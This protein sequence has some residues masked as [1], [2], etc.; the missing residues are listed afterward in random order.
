MLIAVIIGTSGV[1]GGH[2]TIE[3]IGQAMKQNRGQ[4]CPSPDKQPSENQPGQK[5]QGRYYLALYDDM[6]NC[7]ASSRHHYAYPVLQSAPA[8]N[9]A[10]ARSPA[11]CQPMDVSQ[12]ITPE[13]YFFRNR[14]VHKLI[15]YPAKPLLILRRQ[16]LQRRSQSAGVQQPQS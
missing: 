4:Q 2:N 11:G 7:K 5:Y 14:D 10:S 1:N 15:E 8:L 13:K 12:H 16:R 9:C 6:G 3:G